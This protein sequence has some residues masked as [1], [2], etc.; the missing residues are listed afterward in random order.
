MICRICSH[1]VIIM[2]DAQ[3]ANS[4]PPMISACSADYQYWHVALLKIWFDPDVRQGIFPYGERLRSD[5][6]W[7]ES[8]KLQCWLLYWKYYCS[9]I[10]AEKRHWC[11]CF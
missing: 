11:D 1:A 3:R 4:S 5:G 9:R 6:V 2:M 10:A 8:M 7:E